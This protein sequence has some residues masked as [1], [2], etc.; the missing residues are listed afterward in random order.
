MNKVQTLGVV[1]MCLLA[2]NAVAGAMTD[3]SPFAVKYKLVERK[4]LGSGMFRYS[5]ILTLTNEQRPWVDATA[6]VSTD[7]D[8]VA[9][10]NDTLVI[11]DLR[12]GESV[13]AKEPLIVIADARNAVLVPD[14][15][16]VRNL[17]PSL[18]RA[19]PKRARYG[20]AYRKGLEVFSI[21]DFR[22]QIFAAAGDGIPPDPGSVGDETLAGVDSD[23][24][25]VRDD[26]ERDIAKITPSPSD[27]AVRR[28]AMSLGRALQKTVDPG[29]IPLGA[30]R[31]EITRAIACVLTASDAGAIYVRVIENQFTDTLERLNAYLAYNKALDGTSWRA[32]E[33][34]DG[35]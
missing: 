7:I 12:P 33:A 29:A 8:G 21:N 32:Q 1:L 11:G 14:A 26:L 2:T 35:E 30:I 4:P 23:E 9:I 3:Q 27:E 15:I 24:D 18:K 19:H 5:F 16:R 31:E 10:E 25:G 13:V 28:A 20:P 6:V 34:C 17:R 22:T